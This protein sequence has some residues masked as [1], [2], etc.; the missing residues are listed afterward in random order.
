MNKTLAKISERHP[1]GQR[2]RYVNP[3]RRGDGGEA[4]VVGYLHRTGTPDRV[5]YI[6]LAFGDRRHVVTVS[7]INKY[8]VTI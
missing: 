7:Q 1:V 6:E 4:E 2:Y 3:G 8:Y 5:A